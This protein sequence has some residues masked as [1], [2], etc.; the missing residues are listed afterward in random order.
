MVELVS[1][2][3]VITEA[4]PSSYE[5]LNVWVLLSGDILS[6]YFADLSDNPMFTL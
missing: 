3:S 4:T 6:I 1:G 2:G 5:A